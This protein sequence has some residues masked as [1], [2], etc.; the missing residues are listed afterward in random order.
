MDPPGEVSLYEPH[1]YSYMLDRLCSNNMTNKTKI[2]CFPSA[3]PFSS[4]RDARHEAK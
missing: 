2:I 3:R 1:L 4:F